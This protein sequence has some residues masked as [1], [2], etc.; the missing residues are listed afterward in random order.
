VIT[1]NATL[2]SVHSGQVVDAAWTPHGRL[3]CA[4]VRSRCE[5][6]AVYVGLMPGAFQLDERWSWWVQRYGR[7][8]GFVWR[9]FSVGTGA[10]GFR[11]TSGAGST[12]LVIQRV[13]SAASF[14]PWPYSPNQS[15]LTRLGVHLVL[16]AIDIEFVRLACGP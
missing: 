7:W 12:P 11:S 1:C 8:S 4:L 10:N 5:R 6:F 3:I 13:S 14:V 2:V 16:T 15:I 9:R